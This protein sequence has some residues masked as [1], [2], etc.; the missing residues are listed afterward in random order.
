LLTVV[1]TTAYAALTRASDYGAVLGIASGELGRPQPDVE[2]LTLMSPVSATLAVLESR[3]ADGLVVVRVAS[4][5]FTHWHLYAVRFFSGV[6]PRLFPAL[7]AL[8]PLVPAL[9]PAL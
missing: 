6:G 1:E 3:R 2:V 9:N 4:L 8:T 7:D 5:L